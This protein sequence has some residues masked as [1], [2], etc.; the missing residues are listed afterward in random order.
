MKRRR[1]PIF[2]TD[3]AKAAVGGV[4]P[5]EK[6]RDREIWRSMV[7]LVGLPYL[8]AKA[9]DYFEELGGGIDHDILDES[10]NTRQQRALSE[11][12]STFS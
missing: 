4:P 8:R 1:R 6:L 11:P 2:E 10:A 3:R 5:E 7:F 9:Q 12:V